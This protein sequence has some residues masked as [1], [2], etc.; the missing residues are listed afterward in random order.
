M[1]P[2]TE[3]VTFGEAM[4]RLSPP[5]AQRLEQAHTLDLWVAGAELNVAV[6]LSRLGTQTAWVS[7]VPKS[8]LGRKVIAHARANGVDASGVVWAEDGR[9]GL[10]FVEV[11]Q[12][13]RPSAT[14]YDRG[15]SSFAA[16]EGDEF[17]WP[18][19]LAGAHAFHTSGITPALSP[20]CA[21]A[22]AAGLAVAREA[23]CHTSYDLN[24]RAL[25][26]SPE[27]A[28]RQLKE[29]APTIDTVI[30][31]SGEAAEVFGLSGSPTEVAARMRDELGLSRVVV[32]SRVHGR[33]GTQSRHSAVVDD[34]V[35]EVRSAEFRTVDP[36]GGGDAFSAGFLHGLLQDGPRRGLE[37]GGAVAALKQSIPGDFAVVSP[38]EVDQLL[39]GGD[40]RT[41]R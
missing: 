13:P 22:A 6:G 25:L 40:V 35:E 12:T 8:P 9:L 23:G 33:D 36:L 31:S 30:A 11:G 5:G 37:L 21:R 34:D 3:V 16:L 29:L 4:I 41:R 2:E 14:L 17:D 18:A 10:L 7:R 26:T 15:R 39:D 27:E 19:L 28:R 24:F 38:E 20:G 1:I 32:S